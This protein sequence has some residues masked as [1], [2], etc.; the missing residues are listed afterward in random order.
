MRS[1]IGVTDVTI[2]VGALVSVDVLFRDLV[3][4]VV[5]L[6]PGATD[7]GV[8]AGVSG[9][10]SVRTDDHLVGATVADDLTC[11]SLVLGY[12]TVGLRAQ[13]VQRDDAGRRD[14]VIPRVLGLEA[15]RRVHRQGRVPGANLLRR[16]CALGGV[17]LPHGHCRRNPPVRVAAVDEHADARA[18]QADSRALFVVD[19]RDQADTDLAVGLGERLDVRLA[20]DADIA[21]VDEVARHTLESHVL[22][23]VLADSLDVSCHR[24]GSCFGHVGRAVQYLHGT[25]IDVLLLLGLGELLDVVP[26]V[27]P[28]RAE[29]VLVG[30]DVV[31]VHLSCVPGVLGRVQQLGERIEHLDTLLGRV[32]DQHRRYTRVA[33]GVNARH[34]R[35]VDE[36]QE[37]ASTILTPEL[38]CS[39]GLRVAAVLIGAGLE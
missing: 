24:T 20:V 29:V 38:Q 14:E 12:M 15:E 21:G 10:C 3:V 30:V 25:R 33:R 1:P 36:R 4:G 37:G 26:A 19:D 39:V 2:A 18:V 5:V 13:G 32:Q 35:G 22:G 7:V 6:S 16:R 34:L 28:V 27:L 31:D 11:I 9:C 8:G 17:A 23:G